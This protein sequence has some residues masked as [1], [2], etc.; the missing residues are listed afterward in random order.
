MAY[1]QHHKMYVGGLKCSRPRPQMA[2]LSARFFPLSWYICREHPCEIGSHS[3]K[4][5]VLYNSNLQTTHLCSF[6]MNYFS[7]NH[8]INMAN[9]FRNRIQVNS[10]LSS[11]WAL[12]PYTVHA[13]TWSILTVEISDPVPTQPGKRP[14]TTWGTYTCYCIYVILDSFNE[15][16]C[17]SYIGNQIPY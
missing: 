11:N 12:T 16:H 15:I 4:Q 1:L 9:S 7:S 10:T 2:T 5:I 6:H 14:V 17:I 3:I 8:T 13:I